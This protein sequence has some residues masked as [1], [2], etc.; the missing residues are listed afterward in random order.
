MPRKRPL[1]LPYLEN[2]LP[3]S[4]DNSCQTSHEPRRRDFHLFP[5]GEAAMMALPQEREKKADLSG[6]GGV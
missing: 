5:G 3:E 1:T 6:K 2:S 4:G